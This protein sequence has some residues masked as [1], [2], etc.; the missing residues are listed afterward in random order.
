MDGEEGV[1][2]LP[3]IFF[4]LEDCFDA[5]VKAD[6]EDPRGEGGFVNAVMDKSID[7][8]VM[9][10]YRC[11]NSLVLGLC[12]R[13]GTGTGF[14][15]YASASTRYMLGGFM[16]LQRELSLVLVDSCNNLTLSLS[17]RRL[18]LHGKHRKRR[19]KKQRKKNNTPAKRRA[20]LVS[21]S[22]RSRNYQ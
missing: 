20:S 2:N 1:E 5:V 17:E 15:L 22:P 21:G 7:I 3:D 9:E 10:P 11:S 18:R 19:P 13:Y 16:K 14:F 12:R 8:G 6:N 4:F